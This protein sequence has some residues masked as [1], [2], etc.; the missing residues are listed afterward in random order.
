MYICDAAASAEDEIANEFISPGHAIA[1]IY[2]G[3][4]IVVV[5][6]RVH[7]SG[8]GLG[9]VFFTALETEHGADE[10]EHT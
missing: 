5:G 6:L 9:L 4:G 8:D 2:F 1:V 7:A 3:I 10:D